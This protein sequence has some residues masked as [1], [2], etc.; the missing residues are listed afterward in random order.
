MSYG[1]L[2]A[3]V[4]VLLPA[5]HPSYMSNPDGGGEAWAP[6][7]WTIMM[8]SQDFHPMAACAAVGWKVCDS[9]TAL[10]WD[11]VMSICPFVLDTMMDADEGRKASTAVV[12]NP[13]FCYDGAQWRAAD[14]GHWS[15]R[16]NAGIHCW[17]IESLT[18]TYTWQLVSRYSPGLEY[19]F[20]CVYHFCLVQKL[21]TCKQHHIW[22]AL[23]YMLMFHIS[24]L[25][26]KHL[27]DWEH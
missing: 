7:Y 19:I 10:Q 26:F 14:P 11:K 15:I 25:G 24:L 16:E 6:F 3:I 17:I 18:V 4:S 5:C 20:L 22:A 27:N 9:I 8:V 12:C 21:Y 23:R 2:C 13:S 1:G